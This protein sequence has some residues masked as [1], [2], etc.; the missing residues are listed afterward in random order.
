MD[1][2]LVKVSAYS[3]L[4][5]ALFAVFRSRAIGRENHPFL[6]LVWVALLNEILT[7]IFIRYY[8]TNAVNSN[9]YVLVEALLILWQFHRWRVFKANRP[10]LLIATGLVLFWIGEN[11]I[12]SQL[13]RF[14]SYFRVAYS[15]LTVLLS[16]QII[17]QQIVAHQRSLLRN[18]TFLICVGFALFYTYKIMVEI[19][20]IYGLNS[21]RDFRSKVFFIS[22]FVNIFSNIIFAIAILWMPRKREFMLQS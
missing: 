2:V 4:L 15:F 1:Y 3:I 20:W 6:L 17:N 21:S 8:H 7:D 11:L 22:D 10:Y 5:A 12:L 13:T 16:I 19:F 9:I 14:N 18:A